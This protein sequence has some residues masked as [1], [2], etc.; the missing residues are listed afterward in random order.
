[1]SENPQRAKA[2]EYW[3]ELAAES[4]A[5]A[6]DELDQRARGASH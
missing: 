1:M 6:K 2:V 3:Q 5:S 4:L